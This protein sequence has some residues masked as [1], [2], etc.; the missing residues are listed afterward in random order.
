MLQSN[1]DTNH[2]DLVQTSQIKDTVPNRLSSL[3][4]PA[5]GLRV[6]KL[7]TFLTNQEQIQEFPQPL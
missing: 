6:P 1:S 4:M 7:L 5:T 2:L 3:Q